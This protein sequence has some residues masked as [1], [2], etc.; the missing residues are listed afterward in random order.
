MEQDPTFVPP[1]PDEPQARTSAGGATDAGLGGIDVTDEYL[2]P[3]GRALTAMIGTWA[4]VLAHGR[5]YLG[6][7][8]PGWVRENVN[9][10]TQRFYGNNTVAAWC[11]IFVWCILNDFFKTAWKLAYVPWLDRIA[12]EHNGHS[13]IKPGAIC[14]IASFS[15]V[16]FYV[17]DHGTEF[18]LLS[19]NSTSGSS[20]DAIT[21]KRYPKSVISGYVNV[22]YASTPP[23]TPPPAPPAVDLWFNGVR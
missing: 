13:G 21:V 3:D 16:G 11:L 6:T 19:G 22:Q 5:S 12:G 9:D 20:S 4:A 8:P 23:P 18:D 14:A 15:H 10:F 1:D 7:R 2:S 17:A